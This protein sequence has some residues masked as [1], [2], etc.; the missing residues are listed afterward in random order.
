VSEPDYRSKCLWC[1]QPTYPDGTSEV[2]EFVDGEWRHV[3][4]SLYILHCVAEGCEWIGSEPPHD[5]KIWPKCPACGRIG[6]LVSHHVG[7]PV[8]ASTRAQ[9]KRQVTAP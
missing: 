6:M 7:V 5:P 1:R 9:M 3:G 8:A 4:G 2:M